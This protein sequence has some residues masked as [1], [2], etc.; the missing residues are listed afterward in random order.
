[1]KSAM[2]ARAQMSKAEFLGK[3][4]ARLKRRYRAQMVTTLDHGTPFELLVATMLSAQAQDVT[5]NKYTPRL[6]KDYK[7]VGDFADATP[8]QIFPYIKNIGLFRSKGRNIVK[9]AR[10]LRQRFGS[11][12]PKTIE[13]LTLLPGVG[14]KT[15]NVVLSNAYGI[16]EGIAIDTHCITVSNRLGLVRTTDPVK[17]EARIMKMLPSREWKDVSHLFIALGRD[18]CTAKA[19]HCERC[20]LRDICPSST[21]R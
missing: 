13:E 8:S 9:M 18:V 15:A 5:V 20:V 6:F 12:V 11:R 16:S 19:K 2:A 1:M 4:V 7:R 17:I 21:V 14:R 3:V 10:M